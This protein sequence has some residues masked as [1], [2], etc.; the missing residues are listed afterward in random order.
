MELIKEMGTDIVS[1][2]NNHVYDYGADVPRKQEACFSL[3]LTLS[4]IDMAPGGRLVIF[5]P[6]FICIG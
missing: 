1:L 2:A 3:F 5:K 4:L 6:A